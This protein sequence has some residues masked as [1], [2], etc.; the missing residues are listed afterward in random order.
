MGYP[1]KN[2]D[3]RGWG[4]ILFEKKKKKGI[5]SFHKPQNFVLSE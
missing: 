4:Y 1:R 3:K 5:L 2:P